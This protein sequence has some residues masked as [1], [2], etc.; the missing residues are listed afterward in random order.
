VL[1]R[2][3]LIGRVVEGWRGAL[4]WVGASGLLLAGAMALTV[5][6]TQFLPLPIAVTLSAVLALAANALTRQIFWAPLR[7][8]SDSA[9]R[10]AAGDLSQAP[11]TGGTGAIA[12]LRLGLAQMAVNLRTVVSDVRTEIEDVRGAAAEIAAGNRDLSARTESQASSLEQTAASMEQING[13][14]RQSAASAMQGAQLA[15]DAANVAERTHEGVQNVAHAMEGISE[16]SRRIGEIINVIEGVAFQTN[17]LALNAAVEAARA[18]EAGRG[19]AVVASEVRALAQRTATAAR[20]IRQLILEA[21]ERVEVGGRHTGEARTRMQE[22]LGSVSSVSTLLH[23]ISTAATEQQAGMS[24]INEAVTHM[25]A[26][27]QQNAAMVEELAAS[28]T[29]LGDQVKL[30]SDTMRLFRLKAGDTTVA[31]LDA[32]DLRRENKSSRA[33]A[34][35]HEAAGMDLEDAIAKHVAWKVTLRNAALHGEPLDPARIARDDA[36][37]LGTWIHGEGERRHGSL[38]SFGQLRS[39]HAGFHRCAG[40]V[41][42]EI[43]A[44][45]QEASLKMLEPGTPF[46]S[47]TQATIVAIKALQSEVQRQGRRERRESPAMAAPAAAGSAGGDWQTF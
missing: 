19:F 22:A 7:D 11:P 5:L 2:Q 32:V 46:G 9:L 24:Q 18:G 23:E 26:M 45:R 43:A 30:V 47:A 34:L 12:H 25:D 44:G 16:S 38:G 39:A 1:H 28:A 6:G 15:A 36:C 37:P 42:R 14:V 31:E 8:I 33:G 21:G 40:E 29:A 3:D 17:I 4:A 35:A 27:T 20:E 10:L 41:A 13:T